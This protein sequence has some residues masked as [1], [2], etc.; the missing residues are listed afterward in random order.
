LITQGYRFGFNGMEKDDEVNGSSGSSYSAQFWQYDS[1]IG[2]RW[3]PD[4]VKKYHES[5]YAA[6]ANNPIWFLDPL[7]SDTF[8]VNKQG[9][10]TDR[11]ISEAADV[12]SAENGESISFKYGTVENQ[13]REKMTYNDKKTGVKKD[14]IADIYQIRG[15]A[16]ASEV[17]EFMAA[18]TEVE[19]S[20]TMT[21]IEG[22]KGLNFLSTGHLK[23]SEPGIA[24]LLK[25]QLFN[26]YTLKEHRHNHPSNNPNP[27]GVPNSTVRGDLG[28]ATSLGNKGYKMV[29]R[30]YTAN[31]C[32]YHPY[33]SAGRTYEELLETGPVIQ[34]IGKRPE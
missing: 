34:V 3:N 26:G 25:G 32:V 10:L 5:S 18:N 27:S 12:F 13:R 29:F 17:F 7:G 22:D 15:D 19:W 30:I 4:P 11:I 33:D 28:F 21:G 1:R 2:R 8:K 24:K 16:N 6:F 31:D 14:G 20:Q 23:A 9:E